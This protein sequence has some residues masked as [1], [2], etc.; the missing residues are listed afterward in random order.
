MEEDVSDT[1]NRVLGTAMHAFVEKYSDAVTE[2]SVSKTIDVDGIPEDLAGTIDVV[3]P[4]IL[5]DT[6]VTS[7]WSIVYGS[8]MEDWTQQLNMYRWMM[9]E[10]VE[11][12]IF[13]IFRDW[14]ASKVS[15]KYPK[16]NWAVIPIK[17]MDI[18]PIIRQ[19]ILDIRKV[20][21]DRDDDLPMCT[22]EQRWIKTW[23]ADKGK[24]GRCALYCGVAPFCC[25]YKEELS[26]NA[27]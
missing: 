2:H 3:G 8:R 22:D 20:E 23:G 9:G 13:A 19:K 6:K 26:S 11:M 18:E 1:I 15:G 17:P 10:D 4:G 25:Q 16:K 21:N 5:W 12:N 27:S 7:V 24:S 14:S